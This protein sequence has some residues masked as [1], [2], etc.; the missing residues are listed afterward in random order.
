PV[1]KPAQG[2][3]EPASGF[4]RAAR[5]D[6]SLLKKREL[7]PKKQVLGGQSGPRSQDEKREQAQS[8]KHAPQRLKALQKSG[9]ER[10]HQDKIPTR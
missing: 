4:V 2:S 10:K 5:L 7:L 9:W 6:F 1:E 3:H 8:R